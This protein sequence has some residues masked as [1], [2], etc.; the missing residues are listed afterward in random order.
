MT[1]TN[2]KMTYSMALEMA[3]DALSNVDFDQEAL[4]KLVAAIES[5]LG[6]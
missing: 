5:G 3:I 6:E 2:K 1:T 4:E